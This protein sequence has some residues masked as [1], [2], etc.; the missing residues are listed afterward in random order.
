MDGCNKVRLCAAAGTT[1]E[2]V[3][4]SPCKGWMQVEVVAAG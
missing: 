3:T 2:A 4:E 1:H